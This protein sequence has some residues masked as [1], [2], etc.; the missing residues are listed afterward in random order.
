LQEHQRGQ[1]SPHIQKPSR[2]FSFPAVAVTIQ[3]ATQADLTAKQRQGAY[4]LACGS[5]KKATAETLKVAAHT[6]SAWCKLPAFQALI[7]TLT[8]SLEAESYQAIRSQKLKA[9][10]VL[11]E[12]LE[13][14][15]PATR[16]AA[17]RVALEMPAPA[18]TA[19]DANALFED[20]MKHFKKQEET[21]GI[22]P[23]Y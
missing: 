8:E 10:D 1:Q 19:E 22:G 15:P 4:L 17:V 23:K 9:L 16:L 5:S 21:H 2:I 18:T 3:H 6:I 12:L 20:V 7:A 13:S 11:S 14:A